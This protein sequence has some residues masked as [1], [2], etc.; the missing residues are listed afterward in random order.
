MRV[1]VRVRVRVRTRVRVRVRVGVR[2]ENFETGPDKA[3]EQWQ[4]PKRIFAEKSP[5]AQPFVAFFFAFF[6]FR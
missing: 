2:E 4:T 1:R 5:S 3:A 6:Q